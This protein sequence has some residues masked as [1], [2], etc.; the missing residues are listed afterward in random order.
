MTV[1][2]QLLK[3]GYNVLMVRESDDAQLDNIARTVFA[4]NNADYHIALHYDSTSSIK[5]AFYISVPNNNKYRSMYPVS[6]ELKKH[7][8]LGKEPCKRNEKCRC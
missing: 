7:N 1:K 4:N 2:K 8:N 6:K 5:G 3:E